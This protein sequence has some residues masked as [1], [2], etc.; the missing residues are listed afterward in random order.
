MMNDRRVYDMR[1]GDILFDVRISQGLLQ[2]EVAAALGM[3]TNQYQ[4]L[5]SGKHKISVYDLVR[6]A[7]VLKVPVSRLLPE[8]SHNAD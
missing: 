4:R 1:L 6:I 2:S 8:R 3:H 5:E 7:E